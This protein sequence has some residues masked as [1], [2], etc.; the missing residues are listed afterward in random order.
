VQTKKETP[1]A[2]EGYLTGT[3]AR[4]VGM[5]LRTLQ[6]WADKGFTPPSIREGHGKG[7]KDLFSFRD[8][9]GI[10]T[11]ARLRAMGVSLQAI[12]KALA[13]LRQQD[14]AASLAST[15]LVS[16]GKDIYE[17]SGAALRSLL[18]KPGQMAFV[19]TLD[20]GEIEQEVRAALRKAA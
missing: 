17:K 2:A 19:W 18:R 14:S 1:I 11:A 12:K 9:V 15:Y 16:D 10:K 20:L 8:L 6:R 7:G 3:A 4:V 5:N 13:Y